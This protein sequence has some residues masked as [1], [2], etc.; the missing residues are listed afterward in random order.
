MVFAKRTVSNGKIRRSAGRPFKSSSACTRV[1][2]KCV[3]F[4]CA[5]C[6]FTAVSF[7]C[8]PIPGSLSAGCAES[9]QTPHRKHLQTSIAHLA[10]LLLSKFERW[11]S[12]SAGLAR[13]LSKE[14]SGLVKEL[15]PY[16]IIPGRAFARPG[17]ISYQ[18]KCG[19]N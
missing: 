17:I 18:I 19:T 13:S 5:G 10:D 1:G 2:M 12:R 8:L 9:G 16:G 6:T 11:T 3:F 4:R 7:F 14:E 15:A